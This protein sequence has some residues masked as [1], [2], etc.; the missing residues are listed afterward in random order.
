MCRTY[1]VSYHLSSFSEV[2][3]SLE[4][5]KTVKYQDLKGLIRYKNLMNNW[6]YEVLVRDK[7]M[8]EIR[9]D[10]LNI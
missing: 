3:I 4:K 2:K 7:D 10:I 5:W 1:Y 9:V 6:F 8:W